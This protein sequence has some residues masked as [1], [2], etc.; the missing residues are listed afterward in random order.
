VPYGESSQLIVFT[1]I[2][3]KFESFLA[4]QPNQYPV[5]KIYQYR[6]LLLLLLNIESMLYFGYTQIGFADRLKSRFLKEGFCG[7][8]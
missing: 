1:G 6:V 4:V 3:D 5:S 8:C 7:Q 2:I